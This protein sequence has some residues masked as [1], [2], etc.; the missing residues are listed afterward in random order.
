MKAK[1]S[2]RIVVDASVARAAG[3]TEAS[4]ACRRVLDAIERICH[5]LVHSAEGYDEW[6]R[7]ESG[8]A[9]GWRV[10][11]IS[12]KKLV[13]VTDAY[14]QDIQDRLEES[15]V[16]PKELRNVQKDLHL[17]GAALE[18]DEIVISC[19]RRM[20]RDLRK[21]LDVCPELGSLIWVDPN[22]DTDNWEEWLEKG[23]PDEPRWRLEEASKDSAG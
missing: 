5:K 19:D 12:K 13:T 14:P 16:K 8:Y 2:R 3:E 1:V 22:D 23:A 20:R 21:R 15:G 6:Q 11:M 9:R 7:H 17:V 18:T 4:S 10:R